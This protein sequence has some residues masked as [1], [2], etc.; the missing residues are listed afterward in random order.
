VSARQVP[1]VTGRL[2]ET[3]FDQA[4]GPRVAQAIG[5]TEAGKCVVNSALTRTRYVYWDWSVGRY[6]V[7]PRRGE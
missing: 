7:E 5:W 1:E 4:F 3:E 2:T 6:V